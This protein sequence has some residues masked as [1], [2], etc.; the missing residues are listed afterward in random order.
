M[1]GVTNAMQPIG[2]QENIHYILKYKS[3]YQ[4]GTQ[5]HTFFVTSRE[6]GV[7]KPALLWSTMIPVSQTPHQQSSPHQTV[8]NRSDAFNKTVRK[9]TKTTSRERTSQYL[10]ETSRVTAAALNK[11]N[12]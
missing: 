12:C 4:S 9:T 10:C 2:V 8:K 7:E 3:K 11:P 5:T 1:A 6:A